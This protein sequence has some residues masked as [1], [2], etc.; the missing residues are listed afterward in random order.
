MFR[1]TVTMLFALLFS[2]T[3]SVVAADSQTFDSNGVSIR[4]FEAGAGDALVLVHG[5]SGSADTAWIKPG[6]FDAL[7]D[8][9]FHVVAIDNRGHGGSGKPHDPERCTP[10]SPGHVKERARGLWDR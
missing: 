2:S 4:Y 7:V 10:P 9:G 3:G 5:F 8:A 6:N 1:A